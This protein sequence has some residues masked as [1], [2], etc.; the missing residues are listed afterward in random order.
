MGNGSRS[1]PLRVSLLQSIVALV[2]VLSAAILSTTFIG[3]RTHMRQMSEALTAQTLSH[4]EAELR[5][6][7]V[8]I[9]QGLQMAKAWASDGLI[10]MDDSN[11]LE[12]L[13]APLLRR[14]PQVSSAL[15]ADT[16]G[17]EFMIVRSGAS[18][19]IRLTNINEWGSRKKWIEW[20][21]ESPAHLESWREIVYDPRTRPW[22][23]G[24]ETLGAVPDRGDGG[25]GDGTENA[26]N[27]EEASIYWT[28]PYMFFTRNEL[29]ITAST[30][31]RDTA[32]EGRDVVIGFDV[33][34]G[35]ISEYTTKMEVGESG[36]VFIC[37][38]D[39][40]ILGLP[41]DPKFD[42]P[43]EVNACLLR[44]PN[45]LQ[46]PVIDDGAA[47]FQR[48]LKR[49]GEGT[50]DPVRFTS[51][52]EPWWGGYRPFQVGT[53][54]TLQIGVLVPESELLGNLNQLRRM[55]VF[56]T[57]GAL[58]IGVLQA[59]SLSRRF[60]R[61]IE[62]LL[63][64][65]DRIRGGDFKKRKDGIHTSVS[66]VQQLSSAVDRMR[67]GLKELF[68][69]E[70]ELE[71]A[72]RIQNS[73]LP[74][75][76]PVIPGFKMVAWS[77]SAEQTGGDTYDVVGIREEHLDGEKVIRVTT[78]DCDRVIFLLADATGH[79]IGPA[80]SATQ[81]RAML[82]T[83][84]RMGVPLLRIVDYLNR[85]LFEDLPA[86]RFVTAWFGDLDVASGT[87][88]TFSAGQ[89]PMLYFSVA[90]D[91]VES[92]KADVVPLGIGDCFLVESAVRTISF[93]AGDVYAVFSDGFFESTGG[94]SEQF[95]TDR[96]SK[97]MKAHRDESPRAILEAVCDELERF[98]DG[99]PAEDDRTAV[100][101]KRTET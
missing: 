101:L 94:T 77:E 7:F 36:M 76:L 45:E 63:V 97:A 75:A 34:L 38:G 39:D 49:D 59:I 46:I 72:R 13:F 31:L 56:I 58:V 84:I 87:L 3:V 47:A 30:I 44:K 29:G 55:I 41:N 93:Q 28:E 71:V 6:Y 4:A 62:E 82:R 64:E 10:S 85:Q 99:R 22:F 12:K 51:S 53:N 23:A 32:W 83:A 21:D 74:T 2:L 67:L 66:E 100:I 1:R 57:I 50:I 54:S 24:A 43:N 80:L 95:G 81:V 18:W 60:S 89:G 35:A 92:L 25:S 19:H 79:G 90:S 16:T 27:A 14:F 15:F 17:R 88:T 61:P 9:T 40:R 68:K 70:R 98:T 33:L 73:T 42:D 91:E 48:V 11:E 86:G 5:A 20:T 65:T 52:G 78:E 96:I 8:P 26:E 37:T 69:I